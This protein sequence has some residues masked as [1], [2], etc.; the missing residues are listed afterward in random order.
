MPLECDHIRNEFSALL[1]NELNPEDR[2]LV[3]EHLSDCSE[4]LRE[5]HGYKVVSDAY[6]Y[7]HPVKAPEDFEARFHAAIAPI[8][9][10]RTFAWQRW[11]LAAAAGFTLVAGVAL[12]QSQARIKSAL[13]PEMASHMAADSAPQ[14]PPAAEAPR[15][16]MHQA[17]EGSTPPEKAL[18]QSAVDSAIANGPAEDSAVLEESIQATEAR[19]ERQAVDLGAERKSGEVALTESGRARGDGTAGGA[20]P[21]SAPVPPESEPLPTAAAPTEPPPKA[22]ARRADQDAIALKSEAA[23]LPMPEATAPA[24]AEENAVAESAMRAK[25]APS[26]PAEAVENEGVR[27]AKMAASPPPAAAAPPANLRWKDQTF[28][29]ADG[30]WRQAGYA[31][32]AL[33]K[34]EIPSKAWNA[35]LDQHSD[36]A[37]LCEREEPVIVKLGDVWYTIAKTPV[38]TDGGGNA[39]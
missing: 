6:R 28:D 31:G 15:A 8:G 21:M 18:D 22:L 2:E 11:G 1:D 32:E 12:W 27:K 3:E 35:L 25:E 4:C 16:M 38:P 9:R 10:K 39:R 33:T 37:A 24:L 14:S 26:A 36:L 19:P 20:V 29:L 30:T 13:T 34:I 5:L 23:E 7:H 17:A